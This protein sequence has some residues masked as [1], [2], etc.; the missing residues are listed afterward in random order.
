M[1]FIRNAAP[2]LILVLLITVTA[3]SQ[4]KTAKT[5]LE[6]G[7]ELARQE[8]F[9]EA[10]DVLRESV[11][12][13]DKNPATYGL[14]ASVQLELRLNLEAVDSFR[15]AI[16][17]NPNDA[18]LHSGLCHAL[19]AAGKVL[20]GLEECRRSRKIDPDSLVAATDTVFVLRMISTPPPDLYQI[21]DDVLGRFPENVYVLA[22][23]AEILEVRDPE[24]SIE[25]YLKL[26]E[27][28]PREPVWYARLAQLYID[29][30]RDKEAIEA[31]N[32]ALSLDPKNARAHFFV[33]R[34]YFELG[35]NADAAESFRLSLDT[36]PGNKE[37]LWY[38]ALSEERRG[39]LDE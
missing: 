17:L 9:E 33:G 31:A 6:E 20:E 37:C 24:R 27:L 11:D 30:E 28:Q 22:A 7:K 12:L 25:L 14:M 36:E 39:R 21:V 2:I 18:I 26:S 5:L 32:R 29:R 35:L 16:D 8:K 38:L 3:V 4:Q 34:V 23:A 19:A 1:S 13:D 10:L 15:K